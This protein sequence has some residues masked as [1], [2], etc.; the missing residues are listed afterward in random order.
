MNSPCALWYRNI[1]PVALLRL[2]PALEIMQPWSPKKFEV[3]GSSRSYG[4]WYRQR[5]FKPS[6]DFILLYLPV[7]HI[8]CLIFPPNAW[9]KQV[10]K[11]PRFLSC[12]IAV[13][14]F[15][16]STVVSINL[17]PS[18]KLYLLFFLKPSTRSSLLQNHRSIQDGLN[19]VVAW[20]PVS[21][22]SSHLLGRTIFDKP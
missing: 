15:W 11:I 4:G 2:S 17:H 1:L 10:P 20:T 18:K 9:T 19:R 7:N 21:S 13:S 16:Y 5:C 3:S 14:F 8:I 6:L 12:H 22:Y